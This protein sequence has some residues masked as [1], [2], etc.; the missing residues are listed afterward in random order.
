[1]ESAHRKR[2]GAPTNKGAGKL[3]HDNAGP[4]NPGPIKQTGRI[5]YE[6]VDGANCVK[7]EKGTGTDMAVPKMST[8]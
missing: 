8:G 7:N 1:M 3:L 6:M 5:G 4:F 2:P